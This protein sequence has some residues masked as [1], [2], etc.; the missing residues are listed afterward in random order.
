MKTRKEIQISPI[1]DDVSATVSLVRPILKGLLFS[2]KD[3]V[4]KNQGGYANISLFMLPRLYRPGDGDVGI[5]FEYAVHEA[6]IQKNPLILDRVQTALHMCHI[7]GDTPS[8]LLFGAEKSGA[9]SLVDSIKAQLTNESRLLAGT[10][11]QP[12]KLRKHIDSVA[13]SFRK[14]SIREQ[15]PYTICDTWRADLFIGQPLS[16]QW[17]ATTIKIN[18][19]YLE[20][21]RGLRVGIIPMTPGA[22]DNVFKDDNKN[23]VVC[24]LPY[25]GSFMELF[26]NAWIIVRSFI[27]ADAQMPKEV[28]LPKPSDRFVCEQLV[29]R[30][31]YPVIDVIEA[32]SNFSQPHLLAKDTEEIN[33]YET[34][35]IE[36]NELRNSNLEI[37]STIFPEACIV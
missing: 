6:I 31:N 25:D 12:A 13:A 24:P 22:S 9:L 32:L 17:V 28:C 10:R 19:T 3:N 27:T 16:D 36:I 33:E 8:S 18:P 2:L 1:S 30:G 7:N 23:L 37:N 21:G 5:C 35:S 4:V 34:D 20:G 14:S 11:G 29:T 15:L 26:Y